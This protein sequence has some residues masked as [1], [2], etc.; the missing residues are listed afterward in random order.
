MNAI[1][2]TQSEIYKIKQV[3]P[4]LLTAMHKT[5]LTRRNVP[6]GAYYKGTAEQVNE[7]INILKGE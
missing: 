3:K 1:K 2:L 6:Y 4:T 7:I 5:P